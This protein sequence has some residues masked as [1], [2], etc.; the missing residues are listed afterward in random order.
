MGLRKEQKILADLENNKDLKVIS[1]QTSNDNFNERFDCVSEFWKALTNGLNVTRTISNRAAMRG[2]TGVYFSLE[3]KDEMT[4]VII[5]DSSIK[6][7]SHL[8]TSTRLMKLLG[9]DIIIT[10]GSFEEYRPVIKQIFGI[11]RKIQPFGE[12]YF[13][14]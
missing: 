2:L 6:S 10:Y 12:Y 8:D 11:R 13:K 3:M 7:L 9:F 1:I 5:Y 14:K 4:I